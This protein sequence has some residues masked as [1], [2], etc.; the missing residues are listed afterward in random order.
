MSKKRQPISFPQA[1]YDAIRAKAVAAGYMA[2]A[3][4]DSEIG[5]YVA[6]IVLGKRK[7]DEAEKSE[8]DEQA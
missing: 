8:K 7:P 2:G 6:D 5:K 1:V 4:R 3:G